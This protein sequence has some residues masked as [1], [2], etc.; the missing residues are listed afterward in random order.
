[1]TDDPYKPPQAAL[2]VPEERGPLPRS[3][4]L[5]SMLI[6]TAA[7]LGLL[8]NLALAFG[9]VGVPGARQGTLMESFNALFSFALLGLI[10]AKIRAGRNWA[11]WVFAVLAVLGLIGVLM[12]TVFA[13]TIM[14]ALPASLWISGAINTA[15]QLAALV[16]VFRGEGRAWFRSS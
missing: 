6:W 10:A 15:L 8:F 13:G 11:R 9:Y 16:L 7:T 2:E 3:V 14:K 4:R 1:M 12:M 5:A